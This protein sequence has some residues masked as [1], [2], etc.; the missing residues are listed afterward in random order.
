MSKRK[1]PERKRRHPS[2]PR[3]AAARRQEPAG[4]VG[5]LPK[6]AA[7]RSLFTMAAFRETVESVVIAF[8]LAFLFRTFEA[9]AFVI[10]TGSMATTLM[11]R[12]KDLECD[13]CGYPFRVSASEEV[14]SITGAPKPLFVEGCTCP[15]CRHTMRLGHGRRVSKKYP[16]YKGDRILV[17]KFPYKLEEPERWDVAVFKYPEHAK[18]NYIKRIVGL[19]NETLRI[20]R[21]D[22]FVKPSGEDHFTIARKPPDKLLTILHPVYDNDYVLPE[23]IEKGW[24]A[25]W[26]PDGT[27]GGWTTSA[28]YRSFEI[29]GD[30]QGEAWLRYRHIPPSPGNWDLLENGDLLKKGALPRG[31]RASRP[32]Q[33]RPQLITDFCAFNTGFTQRASGPGIGGQGLHW[34]GDLALACT[35]E[36]SGDTGQIVF[37]L[38]EGGRSMQCT[39]DVA[40]G[41][42]VLSIPGLSISGESFRRTAATDVR[43]PGTHEILFANAD[44][45]L[46]LWVDGRLV[47]FDGPTTYEPLGNTRPGRGDLLPVAIGSR[48]AV[49]RIDHLKV[50][51]DIYYIADRQRDRI[52]NNGG[53]ISDYRDLHGVFGQSPFGIEDIARFLSNPTRWNGVFNPESMRTVDFPLEADEFLMLGDNSARSKDSRLW[54]QEYYVKRNLLVG[55]ALFVYWPHSW[56]KI[57]IGETKIPFPF[58]P[59]FKRMRFVR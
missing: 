42:A 44:D 52:G 49:A 48:G 28:D 20:H 10:P 1:S 21:G 53:P 22:L 37:E 18:R 25:R 15:M 9:E 35:L 12:H 19:P 47:E 58:F 38:I 40:S 55:K 59:N 57:W 41:E 4:D 11:G 54:S 33:P 39:I 17:G 30:A 8:V 34:V 29:G 27:P 51:R 50:L 43:G 5:D 36:I 46:R 24:P 56:D 14:D 7:R 3:D 13:K 2:K 45:Q 32:R 23:I 6:P 16:S 26:T 31:R